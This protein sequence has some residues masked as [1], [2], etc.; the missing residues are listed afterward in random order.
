MPKS[1]W[2]AVASNRDLRLFVIRMRSPTM[3]TTASL[4]T[5]S[6]A[7]DQLSNPGSRVKR[8]HVSFR[9]A[10]PRRVQLV[11]E[12][13]GSGCFTAGR[14]ARLVVRAG[15]EPCRDNQKRRALR[16]PRDTSESSSMVADPTSGSS[17]WPEWYSLRLATDKGPRSSARFMVAPQSRPTTG[18]VRKRC[19]RHN[20]R[21]RYSCSSA[22]ISWWNYQGAIQAR[23]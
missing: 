9:P 8:T 4:S 13:S 19:C 23:L 1:N 16:V 22:A 6:A 2:E 14:T 10:V 5:P 7:F 11:L 15:L 3:F 18:K 20:S 12:Y 21:L 17:R